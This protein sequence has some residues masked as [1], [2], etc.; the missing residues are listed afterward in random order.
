[1]TEAVRFEGLQ[2]SQAPPLSIP[3]SFFLTAPVALVAAGILLMT[4]GS[5]AL[6]TAWALPTLMLTHLGTLGFLSAVMLGALYQMTPVVAGSPVPGIRAAHA[7]HLCL[8]VGLT[9][10]LLGLGSLSSRTVLASLALLGAAVAGFLGPVGWA[11]LRAPA[12]S[13]TVTGMTLAVANLLVVSALGLAM[14]LGYGGVGFPGPRELWLQVHL[15]VGLLGW[16]GGLISAVSWQ[17][18]PMFY[19]ASPLGRASKRATLVLIATS[20]VLLL[21]VLGVEYAG[22]VAGPP[23]RAAQ[24][25]AALAALPAG[26]VV[27]GL[28]PLLI[29]RSLSGRRRRRVDSSL[30][31]WRAGLA[32]AA[33]CAAVALAAHLLGDPRWAVLL[34]WVAVWGWAGMIVHG[35][36][37]RIVPFLVWFHRFSP[38][39]GRVPVP[40]MRTLFP[41]RW[42]R[43][44]F[45]LHA[46]T[47]IVGAV[48]ILTR[49]DLL[50][51]LTGFLLA[52]TGAQ[53][54]YCLLH[55]LRQR[56]EP[57]VRG[58][59]DLSPGGAEG[60]TASP[61]L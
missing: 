59:G 46:V 9:G 60:T 20:V 10:L 47:L 50:C 53:L 57:D 8:V 3:A 28:H 48:S 2:L 11:L 22:G 6:T 58:P 29:L 4:L 40:S 15:S 61:S 21:A 27:W 41:D 39:V 56:P 43:Q 30:L 38:L 26:A 18:V 37:S 23:S 33:L 5:L 34:G 14:A 35:M 13:E 17:V 1:V 54:G 44:G 7:V 55:V 25:L 42:T 19:L 36:L 32:G 52:A 51:R 12:R 16:I 49:Q 45:A 31:F 24:Q